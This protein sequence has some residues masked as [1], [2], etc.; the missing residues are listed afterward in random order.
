MNLIKI[1]RL[2]SHAGLFLILLVYLGITGYTSWQSS[3]GNGP[4][5]MAHFLYARFLH[6]A[7]YLPFSVEDRQ[8]AGYKSDQPPLYAALVAALFRGGTLDAPPFVKLTYKVPRRHLVTDA[9]IDEVRVNSPQVLATEDPLAGEILFWRFGRWL[10]TLFGA[11]MIGIIYSLA[12]Q[13]FGDFAQP[14]RWA[15]AATASV[16]F[17]PT[18][19]YIS[20]VFSY[21]SLVGLWLALYLW[22]AVR[23]LKKPEPAWL[24]LLAGLFIGLAMVTK[25]SALP[26]PLSLVALVLIVG[27]RAGW[28][29]WRYLTRLALSGL[30]V[31]FTAGWW[32]I[33]IQ[34]KLNKVAESGW[35][36]GLIQ[37]ILGDGSDTASLEA[38]YI[39]SGGQIGSN[40]EFAVQATLW[41]WAEYLFRTFWSLRLK[42]PEIIFISLWLISGL[43]VLGLIRVWRQEPKARLWLGFLLFHTALFFGLPL[44]RFITTQLVNVAGQGHHIL[45]PAMGAFAVFITW[46]LSKGWPAWPRR[47]WWAGLVL[48]LALLS[49]N[50]TAQ[51][52]QGFQPAHR[53]LPVRTT[54]PVAP[55]SAHPLGLDFGPKSLM[56][57]ELKGLTSEQGCCQANYPAL[58]VY[59]Y[60]QAKEAAPEDYRTVVSLVDSQDSSRTVWVGHA[61][62]GRFPN[63]AW[64]PG[65]NVREEAWLPLVGLPAGHYTLKLEVWG[66]QGPLTLPGGS[67]FTLGP[68]ELTA[69]PPAPLATPF[70]LWQTGQPVGPAAV[71]GS[72]STVQITADPGD[73]LTLIGPDQAEHTPRKGG[74]AN[75]CVCD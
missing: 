17:I 54:P 64:E 26:A 13:V 20:G 57:Y 14:R 61:A 41:D 52:I 24:Y 4:D 53:P 3:L 55:P 16:A 27:Y 45:F 6:K 63:R 30:G 59:L 21:E 37:P 58:G 5:E 11:L 1:F 47:P 42:G 31:F 72:R 43:I 73:T 44:I 33:L 51:V 62:N 56:G 12:L 23:L 49:W 18:F 66:Q 70:H 7:G 8:V 28:P 38:A 40:I 34:L 19:I 9:G 25:L 75:P 35:V 32:F 65:D 22:V 74:R 68:V 29:K 46:G 67:T 36:A 48:G 39:L 71:F 60:W 50:I 69:V 2:K 10:S 15:L